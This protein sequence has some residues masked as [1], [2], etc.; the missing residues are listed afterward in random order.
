MRPFDPARLFGLGTVLSMIVGFA[1]GAASAAELTAV[2]KLYADLAKLD[3]AAREQRILNGA[4]KEGALQFTMSLGTKLGRGYNKIFQ[5]KYPFV[6]ADAF[7]ISDP[8]AIDQLVSESAAGRV[9]K[10]VVAAASI[11]T[12]TQ[13]LR[14]DLLARYPTPAT[15]KILP[16]YSIF[17]DKENRWTP[18]LWSE[19]GVSYNPNMVKEEDAPKTFE[20]LCNPR[21][22]DQVSFEPIR[23]RFVYYVYLIS[24]SDLGKAEAWM[25]CMGANKPILMKGHTTRLQLMFAGDHS[26]QGD[27]FLYNGTLQNQKN[28]KKA[29]FKAVYD[30]PVLASATTVVINENTPHPYTAALYADWALT[31]PPQEYLSKK[32]RGPVSFPHPYLKDDVKLINLP[33]PDPVVLKKLYDMWSKHMRG[34]R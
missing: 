25:K 4:K 18:I 1:A 7:Y 11:A 14:K 20:D 29:P 23:A 3:P 13:P 34:K 16:Q 9:L 31:S 30:I 19:H 28:P 12:L 32:Y 6:K 15:K 33:V 10:D 8:I 24:G 2:E 17:K 27:N 5:A 26:V 22:S 21:F